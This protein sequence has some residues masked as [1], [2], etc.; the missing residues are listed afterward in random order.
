MRH[1]SNKKVLDRKSDSR[2]ALVRSLVI[3]FILFD[4]IKT[5][6]ARAKVVRSAAERLVTVAKVNTLTTRRK[7]LSYLN[8][9]TATKKLLEVL[10]P[11]YVNHKGGYTRII[12]LSE[13]KGDAAQMVLLQFI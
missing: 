10:G 2:R 8:N 6:T 11:K 13:R 9:Q 7:I 3:N 1:R 4:K 12:K 5:T